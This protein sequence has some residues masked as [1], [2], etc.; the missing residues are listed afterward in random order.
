MC[1]LLNYQIIT[2][3]V[4]EILQSQIFELLICLHFYWFSLSIF[5]PVRKNF[6]T[7]CNSK[8][9]CGLEALQQRCWTSPVLYNTH[10]S[11][12]QNISY[13]NINESLAYWFTSWG[14]YL[15]NC[16]CLCEELQELFPSI[17]LRTRW[18]SQEWFTQVNV[19][20]T[21]NFPKSDLVH[22]A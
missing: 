20:Y 13:I 17:V 2:I 3:Q 10:F 8:N 15:A 1:G 22:F 16:S 7:N 11:F 14:F 6:F 19:A 12:W 4:T 5:I 9:N 18:E 21:C